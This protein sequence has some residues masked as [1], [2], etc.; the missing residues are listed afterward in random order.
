MPGELRVLS[1][2]SVSPSLRLLASTHRAAARPAQRAAGLLSLRRSAL[3]RCV[4]MGQPVRRV[5]AGL[6]KLRGYR[7]GS[8]NA[9][10][11]FRLDAN[12]RTNRSAMGVLGSGW[13]CRGAAGRLPPEQHGGRG[14]QCLTRRARVPIRPSPSR[15]TSGHLAPMAGPRRCPSAYQSHV[16]VVRARVQREAP[17]TNEWTVGVRHEQAREGVVHCEPWIRRVRTR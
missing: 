8:R 13:N 4:I 1:L 11:T 2:L 7:R 9:A 5:R 14:R 10:D 6:G 12:A 16:V 3:R 15:H 17:G